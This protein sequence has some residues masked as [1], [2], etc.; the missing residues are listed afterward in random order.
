[1]IEAVVECLLEERLKD[2]RGRLDA[3]PTLMARFEELLDTFVSWRLNFRPP[4][5][6]Q[7][8]NV[9]FAPVREE[10]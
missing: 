3:H 10:Q 4:D 7:R 9:R 6:A 2:N 1:L 8:K 5:I